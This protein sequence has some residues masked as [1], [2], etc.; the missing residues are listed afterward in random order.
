VT[1]TPEYRRWRNA[2]IVAVLSAAVFAA[3]VALSIARG[4]RGIPGV[5]LPIALLLLA[6]VMLSMRARLREP[7]PPKFPSDPQ[8][9]P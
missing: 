3:N 5:A 2:W 9:Q 4:F 1:E 8:R 6:P 7:R